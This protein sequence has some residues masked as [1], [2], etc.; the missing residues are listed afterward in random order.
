MTLVS[1]RNYLLF[2]PCWPRW[3]RRAEAGTWGCRCARPAPGPGSA[4]PR[5]WRRPDQGRRPA[6]GRRP[7]ALPYDHLALASARCRTSATCPA[8]PATP[9]TWPPWRTRGGCATT[10]PAGSK[11]P[12]TSPTR[13]S[14]PRLTFVVA[15]GGFAG[16]EAVASLFDLVHSV[17]RYF[18]HV[19]AGEPRFVLVHSRERILPELGDRLAGYAGDKLVAR[20]IELRL[21]VTGA[22][23][24]P[25]GWSSATAS[26]W[27]PAPWSG[28]PGPAPARCR[29]P[30]GL[31]APG[32]G[33]RAGR[34]D[35]RVRGSG[36]SGR[37]GTAPASRPV[38]S[39]PGRHLPADGPARG[40]T[41]PGR[42]RQRG[43]RPDRRRA[44]AVPLPWPRVPGAAGAPE[45]R[46]RAARD[47]LLRPS[48]LAAVARRLPVEAAG[49]PEAAPGPGRLDRRAAVPE[50]HRPHRLRAAPRPQAVE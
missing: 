31:T 7:G 16:T 4:G 25:T 10:P 48:R 40:P 2:T 20:G 27:P 15:G 39:P 42:G 33:G 35:L 13:P 24:D 36:E 22:G 18:P 43:R 26:G 1:Q 49:A 41:G 11:R 28:P 29:W 14:A 32:H 23:A 45:R 34:P 21:G 3:R 44:R 9:S 19:R 12:T 38:R 17:L 30:G 46:R 8:R 50:G 5:R 37:W 6:P 47:A